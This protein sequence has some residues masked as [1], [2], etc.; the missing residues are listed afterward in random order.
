MYFNAKRMEEWS[1]KNNNPYSVLA[2]AMIIHG[3]AEND[4]AFFNSEWGV[5]ICSSLD[6]NNKLC[7][8]LCKKVN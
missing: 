4:I 7:I 5:M 8:S 1:A 2:M 3:I 6:I